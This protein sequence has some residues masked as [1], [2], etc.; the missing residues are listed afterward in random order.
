MVPEGNCVPGPI[1]G[2]GGLRRTKL[3]MCGLA[4]ALTYLGWFLGKDP[5]QLSVIVPAIIAA[6]CAAAAATDI[7]Y[8]KYSNGTD[9]GTG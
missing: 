2:T 4:L 3:W 1:Q 6:Y 8:R 5:S 7:Y 9:N